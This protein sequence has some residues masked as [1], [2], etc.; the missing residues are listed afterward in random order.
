M[1]NRL[2]R[3]PSYLFNEH[4]WRASA[5]RE[6]GADVIYLSFGDPEMPTYQ[7]IVE[8]AQHAM[9]DP[10]THRY[11]TNRGRPEFRFAIAAY[12][13]RRFGVHLDPDSMVMPALGAK[14]CIFN[15][16]LAFLDIGDVAL[17]PDPGY[18]I[19]TA[20]PLLV[21]AE[22]VLLPLRA[23]SGFVPDLGNVPKDALR[24]ARLLYLN[25]P[26]TPT[27]AVAPDGFFEEVV[28]FALMHDLTVVHDNVYADITFDGYIAP[29]LLSTPGALETCV[30]VISLSK[31]HNM[32]GWRC[33]ALVGNPQLVEQYRRLKSFVDSGMFS[34]IQLAAA[35]ALD[36]ALDHVV[37]EAAARYERRRD[38]V[39]SGF[40][41]AGYTVTPP[42]GG[43]Y[44]WVEVPRTFGSSS[45][46][47]LRALE[48]AA[49]AV[50]P[51]SA[52]GPNGEGYFRISL[53]ADEAR[54]SEAVDRITRLAL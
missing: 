41:S 31:T 21:G 5:L 38:I 39:C 2:D 17:A 22:P 28:E 46:F 20:G 36:P 24:R 18:Q 14:E 27:G 26:N 45:S 33:A 34:A 10:A 40:A 30:E 25:Y 11:S 48:E 16:N 19:Y 23:E 53:T 51:G 1:P 49:V 4:E 6:A 44:V 54:L 8:V 12:Y 47:C 3:L 7:P 43:V 15:L 13:E 32:A 42:T 35:A 52:Y 9:A 29:S 37:A 50:S